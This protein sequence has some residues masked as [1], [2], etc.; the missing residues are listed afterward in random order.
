MADK[1]KSRKPRFKPNLAALQRAS[2]RSTTVEVAPA[3][4]KATIEVPKVTS[5]VDVPAPTVEVPKVTSTVEVPKV[6]KKRKL[7]FKPNLAPAR[8]ARVE[9][10]EE[11]KEPAPQACGPFGRAGPVDSLR[12]AFARLGMPLPTG[13]R[14][15]LRLSANEKTTL[16]QS[17]RELRLRT[18]RRRLGLPA[19]S[20]DEAED[21]LVFLREC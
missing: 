3:P 14:P 15:A 18:R 4:K 20:F 13:A 2:R 8:R 11:I 5:T 9:V 16:R 21:M 6:R 10:P 12:K 7:R 17:V 1:T 19:L